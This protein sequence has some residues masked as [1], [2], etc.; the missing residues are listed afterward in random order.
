MPLYHVQD[1]ERPAFIVAD[2]FHDALTKWTHAY[3]AECDAEVEQPISITCVAENDEIIIGDQW[4][5]NE[6]NPTR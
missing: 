3:E 5:A 4:L 2:T 1:S 6:R